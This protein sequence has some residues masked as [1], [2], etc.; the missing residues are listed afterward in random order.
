MRPSA[1]AREVRRD[2]VSGA[3]RAASTWIVFTALLLVLVLHESLTLTG[4]LRA[5]EAYQTAGANIRLVVADGRVDGAACAALADEYGVASAALRVL[6]EPARAEVMRAAPLNQVTATPGIGEMLD[7][8]GR[9][10]GP[11]DRAGV[12]VSE[13][14]TEHLGSPDRPW[15]SDA[16]PLDVAGVFPYPE[17]GRRTGLGFAVISPELPGEEPYDE[18]WI[19]SWPEYPDFGSLLSSV[20]LPATSPDTPAPEITQLNTSLGAGFDGAALF[21][22]RA[23]R[24]NAY[25]ALGIG[26]VVGVVA[27][28][29]RRLEIASARHAGASPGDV[30]LIHTLQHASWIAA[31]CAVAFSAGALSSAAAPGAVGTLTELTLRTVS[32]GG[33]GALLGVVVTVCAIPERSLFDYFKQRE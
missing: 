12:L 32:L 15:P 21:R 25:A 13:Q 4:I 1:I 26:A 23:S 20:V 31:G 18:C 8:T 16:G 7:A 30:L 3:T 27:A 2:I 10:G 22:D 9:G 19:R 28:R 14:V 11:V 5:A 6:N 33:V 24:F 29:R 17:D